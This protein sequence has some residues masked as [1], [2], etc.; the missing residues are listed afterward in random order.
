MLPKCFAMSS[1]EQWCT[2][3]PSGLLSFTHWCT[4]PPPPPGWVKFN[5]DASV[6]PNAVAGLGVVARDHVGKLLLVAGSLVE[7]WDVTRAEILAATAIRAAV[8]DWM[9]NMDGIIIEGDC[10]NA[11]K[12][13]QGAFN[14]LNKLHLTTEGPDLSFL[15]D[16]RQVLFSNVP[17][18]CN[19]PADFCADYASF[20]NFMWKACDDRNVPPS[21]LSLLRGDS[22]Q[23]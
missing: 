19:Q 9:F 13:L 8:E 6:R 15:L 4:P 11:I 2:F 12:W 5:V 17:R 14:R 10:R 23:A 7:Q 3:Q 16:F 20:G 21:F 22:D 18:Q 1:W